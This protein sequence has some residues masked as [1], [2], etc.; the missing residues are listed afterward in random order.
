MEH[1]PHTMAWSHRGLLSF[2]AFLEYIWA[3]ETD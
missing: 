1:L 2:A 3:E